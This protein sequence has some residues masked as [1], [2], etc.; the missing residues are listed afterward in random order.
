MHQKIGACWCNVRTSSFARSSP[1]QG[2]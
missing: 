2:M 1:I